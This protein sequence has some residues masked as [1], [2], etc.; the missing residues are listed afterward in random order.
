MHTSI[1]AA[2]RGVPRNPVAL[3][4]RNVLKNAQE[5]T[6]NSQ[7]VEVGVRSAADE[8]C[9]EIT[10]KGS[11]M[12]PN[13]L[14]RAGEPFFTTKQPGQGMGLG[15]FLSRTVF[16]RLGGRIDLDSVVGRGTTVRLFLPS[17]RAA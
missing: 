7:P 1:C 10:D 13:V 3:A 9:I 11:G 4:I 2:P 8:C 16:A 12:Q 15:L 14:E 5:A 17:K 6:V